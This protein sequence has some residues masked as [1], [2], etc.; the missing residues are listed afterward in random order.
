ML[1]QSFRLRIS[2]FLLLSRYESSKKDTL[3]AGPDASWF[4]FKMSRGDYVNK[5]RKE[6]SKIRMQLML[7][8]CFEVIVGEYKRSTRGT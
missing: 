7:Q 3:R 1:S 2:C 4:F 6:L 8:A 5:D